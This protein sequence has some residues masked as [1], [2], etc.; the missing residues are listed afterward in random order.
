MATTTENKDKIKEALNILSDAA[1]D[2]QQE[3][4]RL[5]NNRYGDLKSFV[6]GMESEAE[7]KAYR[8]VERVKDFERRSE[9]RA[10]ESAR[11]VDRRV[12][13]QPWQAMGYAA[14]GAL[15]L[16]YLMGRK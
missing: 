1:K 12:H 11:E 3:L 4:K 10:R 6:S 15:V 14:I 2:E 7:Q 9:E 16:G 13:E 5:M 8:G